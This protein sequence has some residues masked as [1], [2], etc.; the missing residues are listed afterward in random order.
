LWLLS[1]Y[2]LITSFFLTDTA[3]SNFSTLEI[4]V[5]SIQTDYAFI[6]TKI[7]STRIAGSSDSKF[8]FNLKQNFPNPFNS[9]TKIIFGLPKVSKV[10]LKICNF[11]G[12][13]VSSLI[14]NETYNSGEYEIVFNSKGLPSGVY[15]FKL[16]TEKFSQTRKMILL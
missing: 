11:I 6:I 16:Q 1:H 13:E 4:N 2:L 7:G 3:I 5:P 10:S 8:N 9:K 14:S 15:F 12:E